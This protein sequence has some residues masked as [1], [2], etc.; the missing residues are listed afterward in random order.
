M[1]KNSFTDELFNNI[2][3]VSFN[4]SIMNSD[5]RNLFNFVDQKV[6]DDAYEQT[7]LFSK[8]LN[9]NDIEHEIKPPK[10]LE[11]VIQKHNNPNSFKV[12]SDF[13]GIRIMT[14][15]LN[16]IQNYYEKLETVVHS[17]NGQIFL[18]NEI[19]NTDI[20]YFAYFYIPEYGY[21]FEV[22]IG[23]P[24]ALYVF[25]R[26]SYLR[27]NKDS[28]LIDFWNFGFYNFI[29]NKLINRNINS[30][31]ILLFYNNYDKQYVPTNEEFTELIN[32]LIY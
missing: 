23:H 2:N 6:L 5:F 28:N 24:F 17:L 32:I 13:C 12:I 4:K 31:D 1:C 3:N 7:L 18:K 29:K 21:I 9:N 15:D 16:Y 11:R 25:K 8:I 14:K 30:N 19:D 27:D 10:R 20:I 22:Q 26:D